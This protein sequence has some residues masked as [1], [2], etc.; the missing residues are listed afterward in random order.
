MSIQS[1]NNAIQVALE[2]SLEGSEGES[3][4]VV[5]NAE[6]WNISIPVAISSTKSDKVADGT[7]FFSL[8]A[9][10]SPEYCDGSV[11]QE[12]Q[13]VPVLIVDDDCVNAELTILVSPDDYPQ[14]VSWY[15]EVSSNCGDDVLTFTRVFTNLFLV[16]FGVHKYSR[17]RV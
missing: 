1:S 9:Y 15:L 5:F 2:G 14:E 8:E 4:D 12:F 10:F 16:F 3:V 17:H 13:V 11:C 7:Q 6:N